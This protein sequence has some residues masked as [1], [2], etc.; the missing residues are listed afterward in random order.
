MAWFK[1]LRQ[2]LGLQK[3]EPMCL[4]MVVSEQEGA[5]IWLD[6][7]KTNFVTPKIVAIPKSTDIK[8][9]IKMVGHH[10]HEAVVSSPHTLTYYYCNLE[11][12]PLRL[13]SNEVYR[14]ATL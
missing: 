6:G 14:S 11:R 7:V 8:L 13:I 1:N 9:T 10:D 4:C 2:L 5:E 3:P 12:I